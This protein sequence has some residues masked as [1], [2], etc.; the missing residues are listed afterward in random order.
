MEKRE[1]NKS[2]QQ[3]ELTGAYI[4]VG[5]LVSTIESKH[6]QTEERHNSGDADHDS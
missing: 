4:L 3:Q 2:K 5:Y 1:P 6:L